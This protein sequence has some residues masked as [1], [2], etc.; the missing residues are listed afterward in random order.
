[1]EET[2]RQP[3]ATGSSEGVLERDWPF[4]HALSRASNCLSASSMSVASEMG[5]IRDA[6]A[7]PEWITLS[8]VNC[9]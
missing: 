4:C 6:T 3:R 8:S 9:P 7:T 2:P 5:F 1:M